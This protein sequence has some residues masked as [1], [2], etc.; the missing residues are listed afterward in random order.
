MCIGKPSPIINAG[1]RLVIGGK[2]F[3]VAGSQLHNRP[4]YGLHHQEVWLTAVE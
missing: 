1:D 3:Y 4:G 2:A